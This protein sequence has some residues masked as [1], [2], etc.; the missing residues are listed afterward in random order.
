MLTEE[1]ENSHIKLNYTNKQKDFS[2]LYC[3]TFDYW[4]VSQKIILFQLFYFE[5]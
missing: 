4:S 2:K 1:R 3:K 5:M